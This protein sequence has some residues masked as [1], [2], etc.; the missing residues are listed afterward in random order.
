MGSCFS[1]KSRGVCTWY[2]FLPNLY[3]N[4]QN[5]KFFFLFGEFSWL[6]NSG[7]CVFMGWF[8]IDGRDEES[9]LCVFL[10]SRALLRCCVVDCVSI[11]SWPYTCFDGDFCRSFQ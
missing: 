2:R 10:S 5:T 4:T 7:Y 6:R 8:W 1:H 11:T 3:S 9:A